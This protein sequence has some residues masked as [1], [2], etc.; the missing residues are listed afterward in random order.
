[1]SRFIDV[2]AEADDDGFFEEDANQD[3]V[4]SLK[5]FVVNDVPPPKKAKGKKRIKLED[6][7]E[8]EEE[9][10]E[11]EELPERKIAGVLWDTKEFAFCMN[12]TEMRNILMDVITMLDIDKNIKTRMTISAETVEFYASNSS[13]SG[14]FQAKLKNECNFEELKD[15]GIYVFIFNVHI[16]LEQMKRVTVMQPNEWYLYGH[17]DTGITIEG[18]RTDDG[19]KTAVT[20]TEPEDDIEELDLSV[21][22]TLT[23]ELSTRTFC[24]AIRKMPGSLIAMKM[25]AKNSRFILSTVREDSPDEYN[26]AINISDMREVMK[27][28]EIM[29]YDAVFA[30]QLIT[31]ITKSEKLNDKIRLSFINSTQPLKLSYM[32]GNDV[33]DPDS[34]VHM[35]VAPKL[36]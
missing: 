22:F 21:P 32:T 17:K 11:K 8:E 10:E 6:D 19:S 13:S 15:K 36:N 9:D 33:D 23:I 4:G 26:V 7:E 35:F 31:P 3:E 12:M 34:A 5:D 30:T 2:E 18:I 29:D 27:N 14:L 16:L 20:V 25:D 28:Q 1:M 24:N